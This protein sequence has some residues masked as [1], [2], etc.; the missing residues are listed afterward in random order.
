M[1]WKEKLD[2]DEVKVELLIAKNIAECDV[3]DGEII[4]EGEK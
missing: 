1:P 2:I 3:V 4:K